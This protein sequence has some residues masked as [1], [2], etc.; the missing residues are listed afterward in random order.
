MSES[1]KNHQHH[2]H[3]QNTEKAEVQESSGLELVS[4]GYGDESSTEKQVGLSPDKLDRIADNVNAGIDKDQ[5]KWET[6]QNWNDT[7]WK[8]WLD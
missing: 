4:V 3:H 2:Q 8:V 1:E 6:E 5:P 7:S